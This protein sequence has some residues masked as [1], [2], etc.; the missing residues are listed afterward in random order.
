MAKRDAVGTAIATDDALLLGKP[1]SC[2]AQQL[3]ETPNHRVAAREWI[4][5]PRQKHE[6]GDQGWLRGWSGRIIWIG[7][8]LDSRC[9]A[10]RRRRI[11]G[12]VEFGIQGHSILFRLC[13]L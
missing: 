12:K 10:T 13:V 2:A 8:E 6:I 1:N 3:N 11:E 7:K 9:G 5:G 4:I